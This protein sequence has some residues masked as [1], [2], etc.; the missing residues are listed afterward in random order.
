MG[1]PPPSETGYLIAF[2][3]TFHELASTHGCPHGLCMPPKQKTKKQNDLLEKLN[4][5]K[6]QGELFKNVLY[7]YSN[8]FSFIYSH[9]YVNPSFCRKNHKILANLVVK[10]NILD[11]VRM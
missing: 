4:I 11:L 2:F 6:K 8:F 7:T 5:I 10:K 9:S 3:V 1:P